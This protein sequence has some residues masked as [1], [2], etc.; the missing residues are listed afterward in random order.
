MSRQT[1]FQGN[2]QNMWPQ[3]DIS[4][5][6]FYRKGR[7]PKNISQKSIAELTFPEYTYYQ[8]FWKTQ[9]PNLTHEKMK[10][11]SWNIKKIL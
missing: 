5:Y 10:K 1:R 8:N 4:K 2:V 11:K 3:M 9:K 6:I 7:I